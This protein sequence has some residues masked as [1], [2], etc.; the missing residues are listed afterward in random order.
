HC[1]M[2]PMPGLL[3][4]VSQSDVQEFTFH[5]PEDDPVSMDW[6]GKQVETGLFHDIL[7]EDGADA[8]VLATYTSGYFAGRPALIETAVGAGRALHFGGTFT[9]ENT[10]TF[11]DYAGT[12]EPFA[13]QITVPAACEIALREKE[14]KQYF[15]VLNYTD[16]PQTIILQE[17]KTDMDTGDR[18][19]GE[20]RLQAYGTKV[21]V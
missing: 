14:G 5:S 12:A 11:L 17:E 3:K 8:K 4:Q 20:V 21:Y 9:R 18:V 1:V 19:S 13:D 10:R 7:A 16:Q 6:G 2:A 15:F